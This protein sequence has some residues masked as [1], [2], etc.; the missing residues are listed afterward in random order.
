MAS[1]H[2]DT[3]LEKL[4][5]SGAAANG[6]DH[7]DF[8]GAIAPL[9]KSH[10]TTLH[11]HD[12]SHHRVNATDC[13]GVS[14]GY[15]ND[16]LVGIGGHHDWFERTAHKIVAEG[17]VDAESFIHEPGF[18]K[19]RFYRD[20][21]R[22][23]DIYHGA[24]F[25]LWA[26]NSGQVAALTINRDRKCGSIRAREHKLAY[27]LLPHLRNVYNLQRRLSWLE[28]QVASFRTAL[29]R[30]A[31]GAILL[32]RHGNMV[33]ANTEAQRLCAEKIGIAERLHKLHTVSPT[34]NASFRKLLDSACSG[35]VLCKPGTLMLH[36][37]D[38]DPVV[39]VTAS[40]VPPSATLTWSEPAVAAVLFVHP[41]KPKQD[42]LACLLRAAFGL[43]E[44]ETTLA[45]VLVTGMTLAQVSEHLGKSI[46]T[47]RSQLRMVF[48][49]TRTQRQA[50]LIRVL[51]QCGNR[52]L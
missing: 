27:R 45:C 52:Y 26:G 46:T 16:L 28:S 15:L 23:L 32:D 7:R 40:H 4:Y 50:D 20:F 44:A 14:V 9:F 6:S 42:D 25:C 2:F 47:L 34:D 11:F 39:T 3:A 33:Y 21:L 24:A 22:P 41:L 19:S 43:T 13:L 30:L 12:Q 18:E 31:F 37:A 10:A 35:T 36:D 1:D 29:D 17:F 48:A 8:L 5:A 38:R 49:K 51:Q